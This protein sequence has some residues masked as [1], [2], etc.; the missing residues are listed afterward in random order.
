M[1]DGEEDT[2]LANTRETTRNRDTRGKLNTG[3]TTE[4]VSSLFDSAKPINGIGP[5]A[6]ESFSNL[7]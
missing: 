1:V 7:C 4:R 2:P 6:F 5:G 3:L